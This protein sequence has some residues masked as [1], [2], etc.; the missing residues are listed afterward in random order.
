M[1]KRLC[2]LVLPAILSCFAGMGLLTVGTGQAQSRTFD[3]RSVV[4]EIVSDSRGP[5][6][7]YPQPT[8]GRKY[9]SYLTARQGE[10][11]HIRVSNNN[12]VP[13]GLVMAVDGLNV[14]TGRQSDLGHDEALYVLGPWET[15]DY[16]GWRTGRNR[17]NRFYFTSVSDS[18]VANWGDCSG[19]GVIA[20]AAFPERWNRRLWNDEPN[21]WNK[22]HQNMHQGPIA[23]TGFGETTWSSSHVVGFRAARRPIMKKYIKY[24]SRR[25]LC[26]Q[27]IIHCRPRISH[28]PPLP[29][30]PRFY[31][32]R[33][34]ERRFAPFPPIP[35]FLRPFIPFPW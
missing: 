23:A 14:I 10:H 6:R 16:T 11:Y 22:R 21:N 4:V 27:G 18:Y 32:P 30:P 13:V 34:P 9:R 15:G 31:P 12:D 7:E 35:A 26:E 25:T 19:L 3:Q 33:D 24:E 1:K 8:S 20:V 17:E 28:R 29:P 5:L 2:C